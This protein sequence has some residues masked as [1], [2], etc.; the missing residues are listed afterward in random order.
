MS[1]LIIAALARGAVMGARIPPATPSATSP[2]ENVNN[3]LPLSSFLNTY[4]AN[5]Y[6]W[7]HC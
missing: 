6:T 1:P 2:K 5:I 3:S 4:M 7:P